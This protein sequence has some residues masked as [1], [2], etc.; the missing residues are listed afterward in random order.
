VTALTSCRVCDGSALVPVIDLGDQPWCGH[1]LRPDEVGSEP[2]YPLRVV[3]CEHCKTAQLDYTVPKEIMFGDHTYLS[4]STRTL[5]E[6]F[7][8]I[9]HEV[10]ERFRP[11]AGP[12]S[13]LDIGSNDGTQLGHFKELGYRVCGVE[14][15]KTIADI[16]NR[17]GIDTVNAFFDLELA[18]D[19][20]RRFDIINA[21]GV[22]F[23]LEELHGVTEGIRE[24]LAHDG[25]F[26]IQFLYMNQIVKNLAFDQ[27]YHEH[28]LYYNLATLGR[29]LDRHRLALFDAYLSPI[30][31]GSMIAFAGHSGRRPRSGRLE[32]L[33]RREQTEG[34]NDV[35]T[36]RRF[37]TRIDELKEH[38]L[39]YLR[40]AK[41]RGRRVFGLGAP[42]K[43]NTLLNSFGVG[44]ELI[45]KLVEINPLRRG[46]YSP[47]SHIEV[48]MEDELAEP[49]DIYYVLAWN[50]KNEILA[51]NT[52]LLERGV[53]F[54]FPVEPKEV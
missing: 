53:E 13:V 50:F 18:G 45:Q 38:N 27:I 41:E 14:P 49:P 33:E 39:R 32:E 47:G 31:G 6:H 23:H 21:A 26:V 35:A 42:A 22:F 2:F 11:P 44:P 7:R 5:T 43:G 25:V 46:L 51:K 24:C 8:S 29:L 4:G 1:F 17:A 34:A 15:S 48:V 40:T 54:F 10:E 52:H 28:L 36:Y 30:H 16:A 20:G 9:A 3:C 37:A 19:L 12:G